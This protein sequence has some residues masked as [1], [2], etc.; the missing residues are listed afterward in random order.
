M[1]HPHNTIWP[2][3]ALLLQIHIS[4]IHLIARATNVAIVV[5]LPCC[6]VVVATIYITSFEHIL[7]NHI[8][9]I[10]KFFEN[11]THEHGARR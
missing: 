8:K 10:I 7:K 6:C 5:T 4:N 9:Y 2:I 1:T 3:V 11:Y